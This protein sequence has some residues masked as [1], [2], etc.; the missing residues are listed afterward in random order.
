[1]TAVCEAFYI[2]PESQPP[3]NSRPASLAHDVRLS[4]PSF[5]SGAY[6]LRPSITTNQHLPVIHHHQAPQYNHWSSY[7][8]SLTAPPG[9]MLPWQPV[10][11]SGM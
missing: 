10:F 11:N 8:H 5:D 2:P 4:A 6:Q 3:M 1:M 9:A 7:P